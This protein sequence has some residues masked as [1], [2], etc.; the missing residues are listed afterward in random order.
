MVVDPAPPVP[1][2]PPPQ[3]AAAPAG[4][5]EEIIRAE[6][7]VKV[8]DI[9]TQMALVLKGVSFSVTRGDFVVLFGSSGCGKSTLLHILLGLEPPTKG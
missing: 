7:V 6:G 3:V 5:G 8:F 4:S 9:G 2:G 1:E